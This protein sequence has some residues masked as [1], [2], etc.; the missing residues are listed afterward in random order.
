[1]VKRRTRARVMHQAWG[2][3]SEVS[4]MQ[5]RCPRKLRVTALYTLVGRDIVCV[6]AH[7]GIV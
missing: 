2:T 4:N 7:P 3:T 6:S 1:M 5:I